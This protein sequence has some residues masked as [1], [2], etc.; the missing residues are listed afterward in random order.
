MEE[1][2]E[3]KDPAPRSVQG[4]P[5]IAAPFLALAIAV[6]VD[7]I[8][9][10]QAWPMV[11]LLLIAMLIA[12]IPSS[13]W[14]D[15]VKSVKKATL[16]PLSFD[17]QRNADL[18]A[19]AAPERDTGEGEE[20]KTK[21]EKGDATVVDIFDLRMRLEMKL[22][23]VAKHLLAPARGNATFLTI[24]SLQHDGYLDKREAR[25]AIGILNTRQ[26][27]LEALPEAARERFLK[28]AVEFV[29]SVR[30]SIFWGQVKRRLEGEDGGDSLYSNPIPTAGARRDDLGA[31]SPEGQVRVAPS[32]AL[33][34]DSKILSGTINRLEREG[35][36]A[37]DGERQLIVVPDNSHVGERPAQGGAP[38]VVRL[39][40]LREALE[41]P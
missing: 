26:A 16:G 2:S 11:A 24:G 20:T 13:T 21:G 4:S 30:A 40:S 1:P 38:R 23:Y 18:V 36:A 34:S 19:A 28:D 35:A 33:D 17:L 7:A 27:E 39:A 25:M 31:D 15:L 9:A 22:A 14:D 12:V 29:E 8:S 41:H 3:Q 10:D 37:R 5:W 6:A 32:F